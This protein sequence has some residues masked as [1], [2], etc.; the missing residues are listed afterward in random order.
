MKVPPENLLRLMSPED[1]AKFGKGGLTRDEC[2]ERWA[3]GEEKK[4]QGLI[5][6]FLDLRDIYFETDRMDRKTTGACGRPDFRICYR[7]R[8]I[9]VECK[10]EGG[11]L[12]KAQKE[13]LERIRK[14]GGV[15]I[16]AFGLPAVQQALRAVDQEETTSVL[17]GIVDPRQ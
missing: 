4:L 5:A 1:R 17:D 7:G 3:K 14:A 8:W 10:A 2:R 9:A 13:T 15:V 16:V 12:S 6:N 11:K